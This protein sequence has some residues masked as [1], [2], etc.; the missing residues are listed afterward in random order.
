MTTTFL[1]ENWT[2]RQIEPDC[3]F[4]RPQ[5][6]PQ[7]PIPAA[8]PGCVH[9]ALV[10]AGV[11]PDPFARRHEIGV[12]W[13]DQADWAYITTFEW[14]NHGMPRQGLRFE[15]LDTIAEVRLNGEVIATSD[16]Y[17]L[18]VEVNVTGRLQVGSNTLEVLLKS[19]V[20][21][22]EDRRHAWF[23]KH[24]LPQEFVMFDERAFV[25]K[26]GY[27]SG[28][29]WGPRLLGAGIPGAVS[30]VEFDHRIEDLAVT[31]R[32]NDDGTFTVKA[33]A[34]TTSPIPVTYSLIPGDGDTHAKETAPGEWQVEGTLWW[35]RGMGSQTLHEVR[36][37]IFG[38]QTESKWIG[39]REVRLS[40]QPDEIGESFEFIVN[41][42]PLWIC[43]A[44]WI[45]NDSFPSR[46]T[47]KDYQ[48][49]IARLADLNFNML[50][51]WGGG[52]YESEAFYDACDRAGILVWQDF[53][54]ACMYYPDDEEWQKSARVEAAYHVRRLRHR[55][56][57]ALWCGNNE[58]LVMWHT[59][60]GSPNLVPDRYYGEHLYDKALPEA[61]SELDSGR[62]YI[63]SSP[64]GM[65]P[66]E[67]VP[68]GKDRNAG[69]DRF[70]DSHYWDVWHGRGDWKHY[71]DSMARF[72][73][74]FGFASACSM[75]VWEEILSEDEQRVFPNDA[76]L[77]HDKTGKPWETFLGYVTSHYPE[78][79]TL[80][81]WVYYSQLNQRDAFRYG[82]EF[83]RRSAF[84]RGS[85][86]WQAN[87][88]WPVT[89]WA[90][91]DYG[92]NLKPAGFE[93]ERLYRPVMASIEYLAGDSKLSAWV[94]ND[95]A[96]R[97]V[98]ELHVSVV[99]TRTGTTLAEHRAPV[100]LD[101][102]S[103]DCIFSLDTNGYE[104]KTTAVCVA[105]DM[106]ERWTFLAEPK[107]TICEPPMV[108]AEWHNCKLRVQV[109][110]FVGEMVIWDP[111]D[112][113]N[114]R[115]PILGQPG[116]RPVSGA[117]RDF[118]FDAVT[119]PSIIRVRALG[120]SS[121]IQTA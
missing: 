24:G 33:F 44:N 2:L 94:S 115:C 93:L 40:R 20:K 65:T 8:V 45:P 38:G 55:A 47:P 39:L 3:G 76:V 30:L 37:T 52:L 4:H 77:H 12:Q 26:P 70:G 46:I 91:Q 88:C 21:T 53:P 80:E 23:E 111:N 109:E 34:K 117:N 83:F 62:D 31:V 59:K 60:W 36:A 113:D 103:R 9:D 85:L 57:L 116:W 14:E 69:M 68:L 89:S 71:S 75:P 56:S 10:E 81:D 84:C 108:R 120:G 95:S 66:D 15:C 101:S 16:N 92:R 61:V 32:P 82:I 97:Y 104:T 49:Q 110:G 96:S 58:N 1:H 118:E 5:L 79:M 42:K 41:G 63:A 112:F 13:V 119:R 43:G 17:F 11:I 7:V 105:L 28:W 18:P 90:V 22:G 107:E 74:E 86:I 54:Y 50:R 106:A 121:Q 48:E 29:D 72:S 100:S 25:R 78:P 35:P 114:V 73:S 98:G 27:M 64:I 19:A 87:D 67:S 99:D 6:K 51:V 102:N